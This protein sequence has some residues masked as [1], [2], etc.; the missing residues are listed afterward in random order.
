MD[1]IKTFFER[2]AI[3]FMAKEKQE[4]IATLESYA[5]AFLTFKPNNVIGYFDKPL[6]MLLDDGPHVFDTEEKI[7]AYLASYMKDL[8]DKHYAHDK[9][10][11]SH[12]KSISKTCVVASFHLVR[13]NTSGQPFGDFGAMYTWHKT[14]GKWKLIIGV[15]LSDGDV[16][17]IPKN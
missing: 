12:F 9:L 16:L 11:K 1:K 7:L 6:T 15:L 14:D 2:I 3:F 13:V 5:E 4:V 8:Q 17:P 10:T